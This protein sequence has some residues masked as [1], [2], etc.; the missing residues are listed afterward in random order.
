M[1]HF[2]VR[3]PNSPMLQKN[4]KIQ[5]ESIRFSSDPNFYRQDEEESQA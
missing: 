4:L 3:I 1:E 5:H 2:E